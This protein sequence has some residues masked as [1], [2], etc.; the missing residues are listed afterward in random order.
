MRQPVRSAVRGYDPQPDL[1]LPEARRLA[2]DPQIASER[3][4]AATTQRVAAHGGDRRHGELLDLQEQARVDAAQSVGGAPVAQLAD[5]GPRGESGRPGAGQDQDP[6]PAVPRQ[7][8]ERGAHLLHHLEVDGVARPGAVQR[9]DGDA[10]GQL[11]PYAAK[12][13]RRG[14]ARPARR[15]GTPPPRARRGGRPRRASPAHGFRT[16]LPNRERSAMARCPSATRSRG[17]TRSMTGL[18]RRSPTN[19]AIFKS[20]ARLPMVEPRSDN[21]LENTKRRSGS[22]RYPEVAPQVTSRPPRARAFR[23]LSQVCWPMLSITTSTPRLPVSRRTS[24]RKSAV[25]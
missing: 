23:L 1:R 17:R 24:S 13:R 22:A 7:P 9:E 15:A 3:Q 14:A 11:Q 10:G 18:R 25:R 5:V 8:H 2:G 6:R 20:S 12:A 16:I 4:L 21:P 19:R